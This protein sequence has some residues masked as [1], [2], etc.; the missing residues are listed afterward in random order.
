LKIC[1][2]SPHHWAQEAQDNYPF[3]RGSRIEDDDEALLLIW[4]Q[5]KYKRT[6]LLSLTNTPSFRTTTDSRAYLALVALHE[7]AEE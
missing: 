1:L 7:A 2:L 4:N 6:I 5:G 3:P